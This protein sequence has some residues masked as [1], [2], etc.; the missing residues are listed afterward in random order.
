MV[1][2]LKI[3]DEMQGRIRTLAARRDRSPDSIV[4]EAIRHYVER[5]EAC[6][7]FRQEA[8]DALAAYRENGR[9]LTAAET[10]SWLETWGSEQERGRPECHD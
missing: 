4:E 9:H 6:E 7:S 8:L 5:E 3:D 1:T 10:T 2:S